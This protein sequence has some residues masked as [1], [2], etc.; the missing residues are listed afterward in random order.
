MYYLLLMFGLRV[1]GIED[2]YH[3]IDRLFA[4]FGSEEKVEAW[5]FGEK[6]AQLIFF[7]INFL[8]G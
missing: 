7:V 8:E 3:F 1:S 2:G 6:Y 4:L 5:V